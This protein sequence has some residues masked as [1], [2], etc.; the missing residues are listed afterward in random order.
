MCAK[1]QN[2]AIKNLL[3]A[4]RRFRT[5]DSDVFIHCSG[6]SAENEANDTH[7]EF[8]CLEETMDIQTGRQETAE[9]NL[10]G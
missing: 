5:A 9:E 1:V 2:K 3:V 4:S 8:S 7:E 10:R 6:Q